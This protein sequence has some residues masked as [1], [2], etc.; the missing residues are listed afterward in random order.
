MAQFSLESYKGRF[1]AVTCHST[2]LYVVDEP[3]KVQKAQFFHVDL[4]SGL[5]IGGK[6]HFSAYGQAGRGN[7][8]TAN[9][10]LERD[11]GLLKGC[12]N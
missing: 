12:K 3:Q 11:G 4:C 8:V 1:L 2:I 7:G 9:V 6:L 10:I 5:F